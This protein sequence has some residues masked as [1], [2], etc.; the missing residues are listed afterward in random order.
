MARKIRFPVDIAHRETDEVIETIEGELAKEYYKAADAL[1]EKLAAYMKQFTDQDAVQKKLLDAGKITEKDY[2]DWRFRHIMMGKRWESLLETVAED[3]ANVNN[4]AKSVVHGHMAEVYALNRNFETFQ[5][6]KTGKLTYSFDLYNRKA[7][8]KMWRENP[9]LIPDPRPGSKTALRIKKNKDVAWNKKQVQSVVTQ[10]I[11]QGQSISEMARCLEEVTEKNY[12][13]AVRNARTMMTSAQ[14]AGREDSMKEAVEL[15]VKMKR[16]WVATLDDR[17]RHTHRD[18][19]GVRVD[20]DEPWVTEYGDEIMYPGDPSADA[21]EVYNC[22][23][24]MR[25]VVEGFEGST[26][27]SSP[28]M[29]EMSYKDWKEGGR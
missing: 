18:L 8:E 3:Y 28:K 27:T 12:D 9:K 15:G 1:T 14:N 20:V 16:E 25:S 23:C 17:T 24:T 6:Q 7:V 10:A 2:K 4:I 21:G 13:A 11:V 19:H 5:I 29:G 22:R 26:V